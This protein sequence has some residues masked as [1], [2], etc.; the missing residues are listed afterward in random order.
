MLHRVI[1]PVILTRWCP[2]FGSLPVGADMNPLR[3]DPPILLRLRFPVMRA[4]TAC[5]ATIDLAISA[6][7]ARCFRRFPLQVAQWV[8]CP[9]WLCFN[10]AS[11]RRPEDVHGIYHCSRIISFASGYP[12]LRK[13]I[14]MS[15]I[16]ILALSNSA[17]KG[18][19]HSGV[20]E[21]PSVLTDVGGCGY[22]RCSSRIIAVLVIRCH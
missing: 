7:P 16:P 2:F 12:R 14:Q 4:T 22:R 1:L 13:S 19:S 5:F 8:G 6:S 15:K 11:R 17:L 3:W 9:A 18:K 20:S 21:S 10:G